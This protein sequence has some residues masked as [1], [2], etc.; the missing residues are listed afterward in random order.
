MSQET[1]F[2]LEGDQIM[3]EGESRAYALT[4]SQFSA[5]STAGSKAYVNGSDDTTAILSGSTTIVANVQT[6]P[7]ITVPNGYGGL[8]IVV[9]PAMESDGVTYK[10][11]IVIHVLKPGAAA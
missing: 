6:V 9:E 2:I 11:G 4:W 1:P 7:L 8:T 3:R 5:I 10:T